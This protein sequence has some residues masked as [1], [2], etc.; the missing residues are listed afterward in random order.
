MG[1][2]LTTMVNDIRALGAEPILVTPITRRNFNADGTTV[3]DTLGPW[4]DITKSVAKK[5]KTHV[6]DLHG[7]SLKYIEAIGPDA[8]ARLNKSPDDFTRT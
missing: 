6:L 3:N 1:K 4:A 8:A 5:L 7:E 2:N